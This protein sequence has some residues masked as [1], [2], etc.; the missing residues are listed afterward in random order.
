MADLASRR[1]LEE[2]LG[3]D[4]TRSVLPLERRRGTVPPATPPDPGKA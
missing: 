1:L 4:F 3:R 2:E